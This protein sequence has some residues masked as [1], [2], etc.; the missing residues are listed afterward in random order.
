M[1]YILFL[2]MIYLSG[3]VSTIDLRSIPVEPVVDATNLKKSPLRA[4]L[5]IPD[6]FKSYQYAIESYSILYGGSKYV[7][8]IDVGKKL[9]L[10]VYNIVSSKY[11]SISLAN[12]VSG[13]DSVDIYFVPYISEMNFSAPS[14]GMGYFSVSIDFGIN[15]YDKNR[16]LMHKIVVQKS[17]TKSMVTGSFVNDSMYEMAYAASNESFQDA[18][19]KLIE[20]MEKVL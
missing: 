8:N 6:D 7:G 15:V 12:T 14:N 1:K 4:G 5:V 11:S 18:I 9:T 19:G 2:C 13:L 3:C 17:G 16:N 20:D 10:A